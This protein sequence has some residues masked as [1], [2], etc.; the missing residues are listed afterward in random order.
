MEEEAKV[1]KIN[2]W[3][4]GFTMFFSV[5]FA[6]LLTVVIVFLYINHQ[7]ELELEDL[8][9]VTSIMQQ[10]M[11]HEAETNKK[12]FIIKQRLYAIEKDKQ[13]NAQRIRNETCKFW[14][15]QV[16][17]ENTERNRLMKQRACN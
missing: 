9:K 1:V 13:Q 14:V 10:K 6:N 8:N 4:L 15:Q 16:Q 3:D 11:L 5:L 12:N 17:V 7:A 2:Q